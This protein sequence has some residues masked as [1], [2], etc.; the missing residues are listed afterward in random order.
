M[1][2]A[3]TSGDGEACGRRQR[4]EGPSG[5]HWQWRPL[6]AT[7]TVGAWPAAPAPPPPQYGAPEPPCTPQTPEG[8]AGE[9]IKN[10]D[11]F[12]R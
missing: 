7:G 6:A 3:M 11:G 4:S 2:A 8:P 1:N 5:P 10:L 9:K 12:V